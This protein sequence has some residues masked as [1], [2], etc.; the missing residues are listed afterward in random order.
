MMVLTS[1]FWSSCQSEFMIPE[2]GICILEKH[3]LLCIIS[4][5]TGNVWLDLDGSRRGRLWFKAVN[6]VLFEQVC[7]YKFL[8]QELDDTPHQYSAKKKLAKEFVLS[9]DNQG[10]KE[11]S[12]EHLSYLSIT[13]SS[14]SFYFISCP[15]LPSYNILLTFVLSR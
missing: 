9:P 11:H 13:F 3:I 6:I 2:H 14:S 4:I 1:G 10:K 5:L 12:Q 8:I 7:R 15:S